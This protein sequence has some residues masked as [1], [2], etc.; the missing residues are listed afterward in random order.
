M[1]GLSLTVAAVLAAAPLAEVWPYEAKRLPDGV[2]EYAFDLT[3]VK[4]SGGTVDAREEH[5]AEAVAAFL[6]GLPR[7]VKLR[8]APGAGL[9]VSAGRPLEAGRLA[10]SF[11]GVSSGP[12]GGDSALGKRA[13]AALRPPLDPDEPKLLLAAEAIAWQVRQLEL[14]ALAAAELDTERLRREFWRAVQEQAQ[15]RLRETQGDQQE[16][17]LALVARLVAAGAC[18]DANRVPAA[19]R[20][21]KDLGPAVTAEIERLAADPES[22]FAPA[23]WNWTDELRCISVRSRALA[24]PFPA[25]RAGTAA[26]LLYFEL[27]ARDPRLAAGLERLRVRHAAVLGVS[28]ESA[29]HLWRA[30]AKPGESLDAL[31]DFIESLALDA[32]TPPGLMPQPRTPFSRFLGELKGAERRGALDELATAV[33]DGRVAPGQ[34]SWPAAREGHLAALLATDPTPGVRLDADWRERLRATFEALLGASAEVRAGQGAPERDDRERTQLRILLRVPPVLEVEPVALVYARQAES[35]ARLVEVL[36]AERLTGLSL[37][38]PDGSRGANVLAS[39]RTWLQRLAGLA[40][41]ADPARASSREAVEGRRFVASWRGDASFARDVREAD[42]AP[43]SLPGERQHAGIVGVGRREL[44]VA[45][46]GLPAFRPLEPAQ[47]QGL[48]PVPGEQRYIVP[49]LVTVGAS[50]EPSRRPLDRRAWR[51]L[52][53]T[54]GRDPVQVEGAFSEALRR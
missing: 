54:H 14:G 32:R 40:A 47:M 6:K 19:V 48:E 31:G 46:A 36:Q 15:K 20:G 18:L 41:L 45:F 37:V 12:M 13:G 39:A 21:D 16:G 7:T 23:P 53:D 51:S 43:V 42:A 25:S 8:V 28:D 29:L 44:A 22:L 1:S 26:V 5:G 38:Q 17:A 33:Q 34:D 10:T 24:Q 9:E 49:A 30:R 27:L 50:A 3:A 11:A 2:V 4:A 52:V 35:L